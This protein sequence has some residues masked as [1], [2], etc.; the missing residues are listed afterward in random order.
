MS[1]MNQPP[2]QARRPSSPGAQETTSSGHAQKP[3]IQQQAQI[4][5]INRQE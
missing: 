2:P 4:D 5:T 3:A 1:C